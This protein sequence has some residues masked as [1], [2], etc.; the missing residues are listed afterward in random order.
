MYSIKYICVQPRLLY[1][2]WQVEVMINNFIRN[3]IKRK[4]KNI[5]SF[6]ICQKIFE[7]HMIL[8]LKICQRLTL[9]I[10]SCNCVLGQ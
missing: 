7:S 10:Y 9:N 3:K 4:I 1:Y 8:M 5:L 6:Q 2:A